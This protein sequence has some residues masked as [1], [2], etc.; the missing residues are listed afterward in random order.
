LQTKDKQMK[1]PHAL[2]ITAEQSRAARFQLG[3]TQAN[4][5]EQGSIPGYKLK[6][7]ETGRF[8][9][10][11]PFLETLRAFYEQRGIS[12]ADEAAAGPQEK[13]ARP[14]ALMVQPVAVQ[15]FIVAVGQDVADPI[16]ERMDANDE[17]IAAL[18]KKTVSSGFLSDYNEETESAVRELYQTATENYLL[19]RLLQG[20]NI[21]APAGSEQPVSTIAD[22]LARYQSAEFMALLGQAMAGAPEGEQSEVEEAEGA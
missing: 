21:V 7:F 16:L 3:L 11:M 20:R 10:D 2:P 18:I 15:R 17:R 6:Q 8:V 12:F 22:L 5:I 9:P 13:P 14:G 4:V 1:I 19:F